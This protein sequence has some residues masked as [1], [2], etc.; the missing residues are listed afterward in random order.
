MKKLLLSALLTIVFLSG[1]ALPPPTLKQ[2]ESISYGPPLAAAK[3]DTLVREYVEM[4]LV[5]PLS[6]M[7]RFGEI[8]RVWYWDRDKDDKNRKLCGGWGVIVD[9]NSKNTYGGYTGWKT[10]V[11]MITDGK[12]CKFDL[13]MEAGTSLGKEWDFSDFFKKEHGISK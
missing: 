13:P 10:C 5:D 3:A 12:V 1:C 9:I 6:A 2:F 11:F 7:Y 8:S 4:R